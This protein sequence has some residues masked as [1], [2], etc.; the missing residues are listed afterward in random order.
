LRK[1]SWKPEWDRTDKEP[2]WATGEASRN[3]HNPFGSNKYL[4]GN[5]PAIDV[6]QLSLN[7]G[8]RYDRDIKLLFA[9]ELITGLVGF[10][11]L[12]VDSLR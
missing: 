7:E 10:L 6:L 5:V 2:T 4:W 1:L 11:L 8:E 3:V 9:G 12:T